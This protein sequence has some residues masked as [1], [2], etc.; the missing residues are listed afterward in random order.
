MSPENLIELI[1]K[2]ASEHYKTEGEKEA[3]LEGFYKEA[4]VG[5][6]Q[7]GS[8]IARYS[9]VT[10]RPTTMGRPLAALGVG[11]AGAAIVKGINSA[12]AI[13]SN[14]LTRNKFEAALSQVMQNNRVVRGADPVKA[15]NYAETIFSFAPHVASDANLLSSILAN[16]VHGE[17]I[18]P[19]TIKTLVDL[20]GR[21]TDNNESRPFTGIR[22]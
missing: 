1:E 12:T 7:L 15:K 17:G 20:E 22:T 3:F 13:T 9:K 4:F 2:E 16:A 18:D 19:M 14:L 10:L 8:T 5:L 6:P 11:L 21:Y